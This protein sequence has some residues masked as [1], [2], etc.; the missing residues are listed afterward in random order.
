VLVEDGVLA[1]TRTVLKN[2]KEATR[3]K[4]GNKLLLRGTIT[5]AL[6]VLRSKGAVAGVVQILGMVPNV[7]PL[8]RPHKVDVDFNGDPGKE[9]LVGELAS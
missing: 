7:I 2:L 1:H 8:I 5:Q 3:N 4:T 6:H 9:V